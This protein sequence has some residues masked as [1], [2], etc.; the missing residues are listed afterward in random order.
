MET[1]RKQQAEK[2]SSL[3]RDSQSE[4][5]RELEAQLTALRDEKQRIIGK[6]RELRQ[7]L[8]QLQQERVRERAQAQS[9][10]PSSGDAD[11]HVKKIM[12]VVYQSVKRQLG[13]TER[14]VRVV[15]FEAL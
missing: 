5:V 12:N 7:Q 13:A 11:A 2:L 8:L 10:A 4:K 14:Y 15:G 6:G 3:E 1:S 9:T